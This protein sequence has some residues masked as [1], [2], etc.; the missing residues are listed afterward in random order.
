M[1][2]TIAAPICL[3]VAATIHCGNTGDSA[4]DPE[5]PS[6]SGA[7]PGSEASAADSESRD[8]S[9]PAAEGG[10]SPPV[11]G[12][13]MLATSVSQFGITWTFD[14]PHDVG[15]FANGD[16]WV[17]GPV[18]IASVSPAPTTDRNGSVV[19]PPIGNGQGYDGRGYDYNAS[20]RASFP[21]TLTAVSSLVSSISH[22]GSQCVF[23]GGI[24][25]YS[26]YDGECQ[27]GPVETQAVLTVVA[28]RPPPGTFRPPYAGK[29]I[30]P[31]YSWSMIDW[32][33][34]PKLP[35]PASAPS[36]SA[37]L[38]HVERPWIDHMVNWT[39][40]Y[41]CA[42]QNMY[43]YGREIGNVVSEI[44]Q[45]VLLDTPAQQ[46]LAVRLIQLGIDNYGIVKNGFAW[47]S[48]GGHMNGRK[49]PIVF[50]GLMLNDIGMKRPGEISGED[51]QTYRG[52]NG[53]A[54]WG[55]TCTS[56][57]FPNACALG[58]SC[59]GGRQD[60]KDPAGLIDGCDGYRNCCTSLTWPGQALAILVL[61]AKN[62][63]NHDPF[64]DYV[65][66]WMAGDVPEG[67]SAGSKFV[68][69]MWKKYRNNLP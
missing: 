3:L 9:S 16:P 21:L 40:Q 10:P 51:Q 6:D 28:S 55:A 15:Q 5:T 54:L 69:D 61:K 59:N 11:G 29:D 26:T 4:R 37:A 58:G 42:T 39:L 14:R 19:N 48:N 13:P 68:E 30:K 32:S 38:R 60:C 24:A 56:C 33:I 12:V 53:K 22:G 34:L 44:A 17:V 7:S 35:K 1:R 64:F 49:F 52:S 2:E 66:R 27:A 47:D 57:Y 45:Y 65:D 43:C 41:A 20:V 25:G 18:T 36:D 46:T 63:W 8:A 31:L 62:E 50:A 23:G 67:G